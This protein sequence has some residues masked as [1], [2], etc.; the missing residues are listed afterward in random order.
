MQSID[1]GERATSIDADE[2]RRMV[3]PDPHRP[4]TA[5][6]RLLAE[7]VPVRAII[8][9]LG[10]ITGTTDPEA[11][12]DEVLAEAAEAYDVG[13]DAVRAALLYYSEHRC[14][15]D[16]LLEANAAALA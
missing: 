3:G 14:A 6:G 5:Y 7:Q 10:A 13:L 4:G 9:Y 2:L 11:M 8:G 1:P 15:I 12:T 16:T